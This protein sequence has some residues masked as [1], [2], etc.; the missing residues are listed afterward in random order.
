MKKRFVIDTDTASD[1]AVALIMAVNNVNVQVE[2]ITIVAGNVPVKQGV[3]NALYTL[4]LCGKNIPVFEGMEKPLLRALKTADHVHG[5]DGMSDI[6]LPLQGF[7]PEKNHAVS[8]LISR[9]NQSPNEL[10]LVCLG[11]LTNIAMVILLDK[12]IVHKLKE[13]VI[14]GGVG[15]GRGNVTPISEY[16]FW[17]DPEAAKIVFESGMK[18][19]MVGW[20]ISRKYA[21]FDDA[22]VAKLRAVGTPLA[23]FAVDIQ[24]TLVEYAQNSS[25]LTGFDL[26]DPIA[27]AVAID[28]SIATES[29]MAF[30]TILTNDDYSRGQ[31]A[32]DYTGATGQKPNAE[33]VLKADG[34]RFKALLRD[35]LL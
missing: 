15:E 32:I 5:K 19:K 16:N 31:S 35:S 1:D 6:G 22:E 34:E 26:P 10:S 20:D 25:H 24:K 28:S 9:I 17:A 30:V 14:M 7:V 21:V 12:A 11:P 3:Q 33:I 4:Q 2:A 29:K 13:C 23:N 27:M 8:E 18:I